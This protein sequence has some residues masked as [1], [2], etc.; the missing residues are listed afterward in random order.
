MFMMFA[1][2]MQTHTHITPF[3]LV[4]INATPDFPIFGELTGIGI[5]DPYQL[6]YV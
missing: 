5:W 6:P 3:D 2:Q 1:C 4:L